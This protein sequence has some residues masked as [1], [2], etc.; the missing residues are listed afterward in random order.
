[1]SPRPSLTGLH[2]SHGSMDAESHGWSLIAWTSALPR[3]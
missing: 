3:W 1:M 2:E